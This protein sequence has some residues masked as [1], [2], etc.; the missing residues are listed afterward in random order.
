MPEISPNRLSDGANTLEGGM[1]SGRAAQLLPPNQAANLINTTVRGGYPTCRPPF[2]NCVFKFENDDQSAFFSSNHCQGAIIYQPLSLDSA[3]FAVLQIGGRT[4]TV[5]VYG[6]CSVM[7]ITV[8]G[9][10]NPSVLPFAWM[11]QGEQYLFIQDGQSRPL[12]YDGATLRRALPFGLPYWEMPVGTVMEYAFGRMIVAHDREYIIGDINGGPT[13]IYQF[14]ENSFVAEG[15]SY[16]VPIAGDITALRVMAALDNAI[17]QGPLTIHTSYGIC[18]A[19][20]DVPR[21]TWKD[22]QFQQ[23]AMI[24]NGGL[25]QNSTVLVNSDLWMRAK[26]GWRSFIL[27]MRDF[28]SWGNV[29]QS[30]ELDLLLN[31]DIKPL[32]RYGSAILFDNR[33]IQTVNPAPDGYGFYHQ[34]LSILDFHLLSS[35]HDKASPAYEGL[36]TGIKPVHVFKGQWGFAERCFIIARSVTGAV[37]LWELLKEG[38]FD[39]GIKPIVWQLELRS[40]SF[41]DPNQRK[42]LDGGELFINDLIGSASFHVEYVPDDYPCYFDWYTNTECAKY[43]TCSPTDCKIPTLRAQYRT[44][45]NLPQPPDVCAPGTSPLRPPRFFYRLQPRITI[46]GKAKI[47]KMLFH[48]NNQFQSP[49]ELCTVS[50]DC[51]SLDC[52]PDSPYTYTSKP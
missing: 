27:G 28:Q 32:L 12:I 41:G 9:D 36:W 8:A 48:A 33:L 50:G 21:L 10:P 51:V 22:I 5:Q 26:D 35:L 16:N 18:T 23:T 29:P 37:E 3:P 6:D 38:N 15:G 39:N 44:R 45:W 49:S 20:I 4:F 2:Q 14:T 25:G 1:N 31:R 46:N 7:E 11:K 30:T 40:M 19:R 52:C 43:Q 24:G 17:G 34:G 47:T 42:R 13:Q